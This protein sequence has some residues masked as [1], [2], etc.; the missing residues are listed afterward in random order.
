[1]LAAKTTMTNKIKYFLVLPLLILIALPWNASMPTRGL[2]TS[3]VLAINK[4]VADGKDFRNSISFT[5]GPYAAIYTEAYYPGIFWLSL[6][7]SFAICFAFFWA[8]HRPLSLVSLPRSLVAIFP[9]LT[10]FSEKMESIS[11]GILV[12]DTFYVCSNMSRSLN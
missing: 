8:L 3:W 4:A 9:L 6:L 12:H 1:M 2:D 7:G 5:F 10:F 11:P